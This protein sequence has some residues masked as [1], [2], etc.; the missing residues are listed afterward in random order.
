ERRF[1]EALTV[2]QRLLDEYP[3]VDDGL[4]R[5]ARVH[6]AMGNHALAA[7]FWRRALHFIE[8]PE[9]RPFFDPEVFEDYRQR[10]NAARERA[11]R[12]PDAAA[13]RASLAE[14]DQAP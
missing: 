13:Q 3:D 12:S 8:N 1:D 2:C 7:D 9:R 10:L 6:D 4:E 5:S 11:A 14:E